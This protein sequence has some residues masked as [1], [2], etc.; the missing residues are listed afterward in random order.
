MKERAL[1]IVLDTGDTVSAVLSEPDPK[2]TQQETCIA[3]AHGMI[4]LGYPLQ[5]RFTQEF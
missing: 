4:F 3:V 2:K 5:Q 1:S